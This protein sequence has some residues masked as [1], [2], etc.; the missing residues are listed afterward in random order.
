MRFFG[1]AVQLVALSLAGCGGGTD[2]ADLVQNRLK[3]PAMPSAIPNGVFG[4]PQRETAFSP[5]PQPL[6]NTL[7]ETVNSL[8]G[9]GLPLKASAKAGDPAILFKVRGDGAMLL[10]RYRF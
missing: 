3:L 1:L 8:R 5:N 10:W 7:I 9:E 4:E 6:A 2:R